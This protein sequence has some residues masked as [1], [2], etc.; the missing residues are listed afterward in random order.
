MK[1]AFKFL[2]LSVLFFVLIHPTQAQ[3]GNDPC[4]IGYALSTV[5]TQP[6]CYGENTG[7][8]AVASTGCDCMFSGCTYVWETIQ[9]E[10]LEGQI[11]H[12]AFDLAPG[13]YKVT[14]THPDGCVMDTAIVVQ[15]ANNLIEEVI[16]QPILCK[17]AN[18]GRI[19][20]VPTAENET[21][22]TYLWNTTA[23]TATIENLTPGNYQVIITNPIGCS[24]TEVFTV[25][26]EAETPLACVFETVESCENLDNGV[27]FLTA[28]GG[29]SPYEYR[30]EEY[31]YQN[32]S[33]FNNLSSGTYKVFMRDAV[34]CETSM[35]IEIPAVPIPEP[36]IQTGS[37]SLCQGE[38][39]SLQ[40]HTDVSNLTYTWSPEEG[41]SNPNSNIVIASPEET[42]TYTITIRNEAG[43]E[44]SKSITVEVEECAE[45][46]NAVPSITLDKSLSFYPNPVRDILNIQT[47]KTAVVKIFDQN[48]KTVRVLEVNSGQ[49]Q[50]EFQDFPKGIYFLLI[51][52]EEGVFHH[53]LV[54]E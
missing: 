46:V 45:Q 31:D 15:E 49:N 24:V 17:N 2:L 36:V 47:P 42:T 40:V 37:S 39:T 51:E 33:V 11:F 25:T 50:I 38:L 20:I 35:E 3:D 44:N 18:D 27:I 34:G 9:G 4:E 43:C 29:I 52:N 30:L 10:V 19:T 6:L 14:V 12:T 21:G 28:Q 23:Q 8:A 13:D 16:V 41:I 48:G 32:E 26:E 7:T 53:K 1:T 5:S 54:K 22:M